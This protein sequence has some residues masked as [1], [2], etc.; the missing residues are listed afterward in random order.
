M[1]LRNFAFDPIRAEVGPT[2]RHIDSPI[3]ARYTD[4]RG[5][6]PGIARFS[7]ARHGVDSE[8]HCDRHKMGKAMK[9][10]FPDTIFRNSAICE[11]TGMDSP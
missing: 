8:H 2:T 1:L 6:V 5:H 3:P 11:E 10:T 9:V 7:N 4:G